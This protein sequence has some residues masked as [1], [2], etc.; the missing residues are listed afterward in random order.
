MLPPRAAVAAAAAMALAV[1]L[2]GCGSSEPKPALVEK[3]WAPAMPSAG[4]GGRPRPQAAPAVAHSGRFV[5]DASAAAEPEHGA[6]V[7][8]HGSREAGDVVVEVVGEGQPIVMKSPEADVQ[9]ELPPAPEAAQ[10][11]AQAQ[12][13]AAG[14]TSADPVQ[15][16]F[17]NEAREPVH[18]FWVNPDGG[19]ETSIGEIQPETQVAHNSFH[20]HSWVVRSAAGDELVRW[21][22][23]RAAGEAQTVSIRSPPQAPAGQGFTDADPVQVTFT[24]DLAAAVTLL[25][26]DPSTGGELRIAELQPSQEVPQGTFHSH[27]W[28]A[29]DGAGDAVFRW[30]ADRASGERQAVHIDGRLAVRFVNRGGAPVQLFW[31]NKDTNEMHFQGEIGPDQELEIGTAAGHR[32]LAKAADGSVVRDWIARADSA[33]VQHVEL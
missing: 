5:S 29:R 23:D 8:P 19:A 32:F 18:L 10:A 11:Q 14:F 31:V 13:P 1:L 3:P 24:N 15:V 2:A 17:A 30:V 12:A 4:A 25:W 27:S 33:V 20:G 22:A 28:V 7:R 26:V 6:R 16:Q 21:A 9:G